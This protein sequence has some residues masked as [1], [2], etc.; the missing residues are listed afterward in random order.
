[1]GAAPSTHPGRVV[2]NYGRRVLVRDSSG[3]THLCIPRG[4]RLGVVCGDWVQWEPAASGDFGTVLSVEARSSE[5]TRPDHRGRPEVL[6]ANVTLVAAVMAPEPMPDPFIIDRYLAAAALMGADAI[7]VV[8]K[9]DRIDDKWAGRLDD[10][11]SE[12][13]GAGYDV[14][15]TSARTAEGIDDLAACLAG[16]TGILAGQSGVGKSSLLNRL[17]PAIDAATASVSSATGEGRHTTT[18]SV[19]HELPGGGEIIDSPGVRD[20]APG[21][22]EPREVAAG[23][24]EFADHVPH[25]RFANC[26]H[27]DEP[28]CAVKAAVAD[29][30]IAERRYESYRRLVR[31]MERLAPKY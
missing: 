21:V 19:L 20:Y 23:F 22:V 2:A 8:N 28:G 18:A 11:A 24:V 5:L 6:A 10:W 12:F 1:M 15:R 26:M 3:D 4:R 14:L 16:H 13:S 31:L 7:V 25:C 9:V 17:V 29:G 27:R 30:V